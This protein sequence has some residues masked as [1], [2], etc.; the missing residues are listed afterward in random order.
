MRRREF[1]GLLSGASASE[2]RRRAVDLNASAEEALNLAYHSARAE[3]PNFHVNLRSD[4]DPQVGVFEPQ[5]SPK[6]VAGG[7]KHCAAAT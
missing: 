3:N 4:R 7:G 5:Q 1:A 6:R 2:Q